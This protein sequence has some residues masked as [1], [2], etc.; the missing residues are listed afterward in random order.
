VKFVWNMRDGSKVDI[1][2]MGFIAQDLQEVQKNTGITVPRLVYDVN[3]DRL[4]AS[5]GTLLPI[6]VKSV[7]DLSSKVTILETEL[8]ELKL[9][10]A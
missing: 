4:E 8:N 7:Q 10:S 9:R 2:D 6:L 3:P 5:Y 1:P